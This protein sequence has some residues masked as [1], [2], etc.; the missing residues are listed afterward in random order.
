MPEYGDD[1]VQAARQAFPRGLVQ[2][3][4]GFRFGSDALLLGWL[5]G[6]LSADLAIDLP[7][8]PALR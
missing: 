2:P 6:R 3:E 7:A 5:T 8:S 4:G 1:A